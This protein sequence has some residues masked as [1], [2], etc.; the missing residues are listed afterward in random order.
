[1]VSYFISFCV[2]LWPHKQLYLIH[3]CVSEPACAEGRQASVR[4][5]K[6]FNILPLF[7]NKVYRSLNQSPVIHEEWRFFEWDTD[8]HRFSGY[9]I[10]GPEH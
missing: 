3:L 4:I 9:E 10:Q 5:K 8:G 6:F 2:V 1:M 7:A